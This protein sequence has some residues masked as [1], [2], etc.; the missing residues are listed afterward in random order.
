MLQ[1]GQF[2]L[3]II[4]TVILEEKVV[5]VVVKMNEKVVVEVVIKMNEKVIAVL[6]IG[7]DNVHGRDV[8][9]CLIHGHKLCN[10]QDILYIVYLYI[11]M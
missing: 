2:H 9:N 1:H 11:Y 5:K 6:V 10:V 7:R 3:H 4:V 8:Q